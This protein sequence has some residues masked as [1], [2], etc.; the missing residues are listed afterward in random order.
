MTYERRHIMIRPNEVLANSIFA[1]PPAE[2]SDRL[3][4]ADLTVLSEMPA[5]PPGQFEF[6]FDKEIRQL[7]PQFFDWC[8]KNCVELEHRHFDAPMTFDAT[9]FIR[10][11][12]RIQG[13]PDGWMAR[14]GT[15]ITGLAEVLR[16]RPE[17]ELVG[18]NAADRL[19]VPPHVKAAL[20]AP[21]LAPIPIPAE[22]TYDGPNYRLDIHV[23][24]ALLAEHGKVE[25][26]LAFDSAFML[27]GVSGAVDRQLVFR[28]P[29]S[30]DVRRREP[31][32]SQ[33]VSKVDSATTAP[34]DGAEN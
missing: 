23:D 20:V 28:L 26:D 14:H 2:Q 34:A 21:G 13:E 25:I 7:K 29:E 6:A 33:P 18:K 16:S 22:L 3:S 1:R 10:P 32:A 9:L 8:R 15:Q 12:V 4:R 19:P 17:I 24:P 5:P 27:P 11:A 31:A 30:G